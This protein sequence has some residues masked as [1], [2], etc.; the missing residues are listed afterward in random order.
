MSISH[1]FKTLPVV[2]ALAAPLLSLSIRAETYA[3]PRLSDRAVAV[4]EAQLLAVAPSSLSCLGSPFPAEC[5]TAA[6]AAPLISNSLA[7]YGI[8]TTPEAAALIS[9]VAFESGEFKYQINHFPAPGRPGQGTRNM[10]MAAFNI[11]YA[12]SIPALSPQVTALTGGVSAEALSPDAQNAVRQLVL[13]D[14]YDWGS[15]AWFLTTKCSPEI[16]AGLQTQGQAGWEQYIAGCIG[17][18]I[19]PDRLAVWYRANVALGV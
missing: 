18:T 12:S 5:R 3:R 1:L 14:Q 15:A 9:L 7:N 4:S 8:E 11:E 19:T 13:D 2:L 16:R 6:Q 10:Q 17:T